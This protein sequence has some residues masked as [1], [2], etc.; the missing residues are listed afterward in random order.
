MN[1]TK[2][3]GVSWRTAALVLGA[4]AVLLGGIVT[5]ALSLGSLAGKIWGA[6]LTETAKSTSHQVQRLPAGSVVLLEGRVVGQLESV[7]T[8]QIN[9]DAASV[10]SLYTGRWTDQDTVPL[11]NESTYS[12][13]LVSPRD[14][15]VPVVLKLVVRP[16]SRLRK[17]ELRLMPLK[18]TI[19]VY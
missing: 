11:R 18:T 9:D 3:E 13:E 17:G 4:A 8:Y 15:D 5:A 16:R 7:R 6:I 14:P 19:P 2:R 10:L 1:R 12:A